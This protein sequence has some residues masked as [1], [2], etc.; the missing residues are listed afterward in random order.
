MHPG[1]IDAKWK[2]A[3]VSE[4]FA[5]VF[6]SYAVTTPAGRELRCTRTHIRLAPQ[7]NI[8]VKPDSNEQTVVQAAT[9]P[10]IAISV[11]LENQATA[12]PDSYV[13]RNGRI[14]KPLERLDI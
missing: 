5:G 13:T 14:S 2:A 6:R 9:N 12:L 4:K 11:P 7:S 3:E 8:E 10:T 1:S